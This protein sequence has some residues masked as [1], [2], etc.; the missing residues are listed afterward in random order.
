MLH[1]IEYSLILKVRNV[2]MVIGRKLLNGYLRSD[3]TKHLTVTTHVMFTMLPG[4]TIP[5]LL[6]VLVLALSK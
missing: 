1:D 4:S 3:D 6:M 5:G 2:S